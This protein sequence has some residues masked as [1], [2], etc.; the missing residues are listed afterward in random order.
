MPPPQSPIDAAG[1]WTSVETRLRSTLPD[2]YKQYV[3]TYGTGS[4]GTMPVWILNAFTTNLIDQC[5]SIRS[6][7]RVLFSGSP[8]LQQFPIYPTTGGLLCFGATGNGDYLHWLT[9]GAPNKWKVIVYDLSDAEFSPVHGNCVQFVVNLIEQ[10]ENIF[11][12]SFFA[13][14]VLF[15][16]SKLPFSWPEN[17]DECAV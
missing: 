2:D 11:P 8:H 1:D 5:D 16:P 15:T 10:K 12:S 14:P 4:I 9:E 13:P 6:A 17:L 3:E 7:Y